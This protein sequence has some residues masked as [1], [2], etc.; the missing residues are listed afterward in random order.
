VPDWQSIR[1]RIPLP[2]RALV[3]LLG[4]LATAVIGTAIWLTPIEGSFFDPMNLARSLR[5]GDLLSAVVPFLLGSFVWWR[6][7]YQSAKW[8]GALGICWFAFRAVQIVF[9]VAPPARF[10]GILWEFSGNDSVPPMSAFN[11]W[12]VYTLPLVR[13]VFYSTGAMCCDY[14]LRRIARVEVVV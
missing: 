3:V 8:I 5:W 12:V 2:L 14:L 13:T 7:R 10:G 11:E 4:N 6:W 9:G 1:S